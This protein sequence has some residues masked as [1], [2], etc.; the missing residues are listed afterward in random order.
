MGVVAL[1]MVLGMGTAR[2]LVTIVVPLCVLASIKISDSVDTYAATN[3]VD[4]SDPYDARDLAREEPSKPASNHDHGT[5]FEQQVAS[6][7]APADPV[8]NPYAATNLVD[9]S[10]PY[11]ARDLVVEEQFKPASDHYHRTTLEQRVASKQ[12]LLADPVASPKPH[13]SEFSPWQK[14]HGYTFLLVGVL[15]GA[16]GYRLYRFN[17]CLTG[18]SLTTGI[19]YHMLA[20][21]VSEGG[22]AWA[23]NLISVLCGVT[24]GICLFRFYPAGVFVMGASWGVGVV[25]TFNGIVISRISNSMDDDSNTLLWL[26]LTLTCLGLGIA[27]VW[28]QYSTDEATWKQRSLVFIQT[29]VPGAYMMGQ[30]VRIVAEL[31]EIPSEREMVRSDSLPDEYYMMTAGIFLLE[32]LMVMVQHLG[33]QHENC[34][35]GEDENNAEKNLVLFYYTGQ[36][37]ENKKLMSHGCV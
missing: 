37:S 11:D 25:L 16:F 10:D 2:W 5:T 20:H 34:C 7:L 3:L 36:G 4:A 23:H 13:S 29:A 26:C 8:S 15:L 22:H 28:S 19:I 6:K 30:G 24:C 33:T 1:A 32:L 9:A 27:S 35:W 18:T 21:T 12:A 14:V 31:G 17:I